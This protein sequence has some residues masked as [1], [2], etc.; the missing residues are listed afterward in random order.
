MVC[1]ACGGAAAGCQDGAV[2]GVVAAAVVIHADAGAADA[3]VASADC[4]AVAAGVDAA[5]VNASDGRRGREDQVAVGGRT[6]CWVDG[7][8]NVRWALLSSRCSH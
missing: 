4:C 2:F 3:V 7:R 6:L 8:D 5:A 1:P